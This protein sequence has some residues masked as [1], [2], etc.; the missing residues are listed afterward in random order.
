VEFITVTGESTKLLEAGIK[1]TFLNI[2]VAGEG[3]KVKDNS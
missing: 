1:N 3:M 2:K